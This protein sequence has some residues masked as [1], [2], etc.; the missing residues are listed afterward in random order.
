MSQRI[1]PKENRNS[2]FILSDGALSFTISA[3]QDVNGFSVENFRITSDK[4]DLFN[5]INK[6]NGDIILRNNKDTWDLGLRFTIKRN[7]HEKYDFGCMDTFY[8]LL[9]IESR[10]QLNDRQD[11]VLVSAEAK[12]YTAIT[13]KYFEE[14][15]EQCKKELIK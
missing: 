8:S 11:I 13:L 5:Y 7:S 3:K 1:E 15:I 2:D 4:E 9:D 12:T 10:G 6:E 14:S